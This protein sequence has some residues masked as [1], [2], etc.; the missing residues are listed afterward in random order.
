MFPRVSDFVP[1]QWVQVAGS[2][3]LIYLVLLVLAF[4]NNYLK[5]IKYNYKLFVYIYL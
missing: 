2:V 5:I 1:E 4:L 3:A